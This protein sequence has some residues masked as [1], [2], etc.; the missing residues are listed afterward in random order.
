[1]KALSSP[2]QRDLSKPLDTPIALFTWKTT[3]LISFV[4]GTLLGL[5][6]FVP[7]VA[8]PLALH[9]VFILTV[10]VFLASTLI[11]MRAQ[12]EHW[13]DTHNQ[14]V[15]AAD[16]PEVKAVRRRARKHAPSVRL[17]R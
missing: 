1:M 12:I 17:H 4:A 3:S 2:V 6:I 15:H 9:I 8:S 13:V 11:G 10:V 14:S 7:D 16:Q 5:A